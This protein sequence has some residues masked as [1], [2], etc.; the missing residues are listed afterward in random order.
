MTDMTASQQAATSVIV[1]DVRPEYRADYERWTETA[2]KA[3]QRFPGY[4][5]TDI[6]RPADALLRYIVILRF[7]TQAA[8]EAWL[9]SEVRQVLLATAKPWL[10]QNDRYQVHATADFW[11]QPPHYGVQPKRWKQWILS[12]AA[13]FPLTKIVPPVVAMA[14]DL[15]EKGAP[16]LAMQ[17]VS[18]AV[19]SALMVYWLMP[20]LCRLAGA[21]LLR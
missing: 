7:T 6:I 5:A 20:T 12:S 4:L 3:H 9:I 19:I 8:A 21:W 14:F 17:V 2:V 11:F 15:A 18:A 13:V 10:S 16:E 1:H